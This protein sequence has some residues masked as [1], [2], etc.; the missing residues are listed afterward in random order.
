MTT[1]AGVTYGGPVSRT[2]AYVVDAVVVGVVGL[3][4]AAGTELQVWDL[5]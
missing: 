4:V 3:G 1:P 5:S 2:V